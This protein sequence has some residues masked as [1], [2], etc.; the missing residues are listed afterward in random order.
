MAS[1]SE[2]K[3]EY[4]PF[5]NGV[6]VV[7][8]TVGSIISCNII[9]PVLRNQYAAK[10]QKEAIAKM[11]GGDGKNLKSPRGITM[12]AY[13]KMSAMKHSSGSLKI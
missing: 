11:H 6:D 3:N 9:T 10:K 1:F 8:S 5:K 13:I 12:D 7:A 4:K 2:I